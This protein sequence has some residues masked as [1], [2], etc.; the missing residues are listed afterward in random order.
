VAMAMAVGI[1]IVL[2][3]GITGF[4]SNTPARKEAN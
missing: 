1:G 4:P 2:C 3:V